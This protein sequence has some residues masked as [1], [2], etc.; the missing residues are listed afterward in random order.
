MA[1]NVV[2]VYLH[3][4]DVP[5]VLFV[6]LVCEGCLVV[7]CAA[8]DVLLAHVVHGVGWCQIPAVVLGSATWGWPP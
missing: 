2:A 4:A 7:C 5:L 8:S 6:P 1:V 3:A